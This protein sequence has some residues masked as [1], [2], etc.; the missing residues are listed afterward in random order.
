[1]SDRTF[2]FHEGWRKAIKALPDDVRLELYD[3]IVEY[4]FGESHEGL[5]SMAGIAFNFI[6]PTLD[7]DIRKKEAIA[8]RNRINGSKS[9]GRPKNVSFDQT[10]QNQEK[11]NETQDNPK[12]PVGYLGSEKKPSPQTP[13]KEKALTGGSDIISN[14]ISQFLGVREGDSETVSK[15]PRKKRIMVP[16]A[17]A[18]DVFIERYKSLYGEAPYVAQVE[19]THIRQLLLKIRNSRME[20]AKPLPVDD[21]SL[22][23]A[24]SD[25]LDSINKDWIYDNYSPQMINSKFNEIKS[26]I[27]NKRR[28][29]KD[30]T[31]EKDRRGT[32]VDEFIQGV[33]HSEGF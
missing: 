2:L 20:R 30:S 13:Y 17:R 31:R 15:S 12:N 3:A 25:F 26:Q 16:T 24:F 10:E 18:R 33:D 9:K 11:P 14:E 6:K 8:E 19:M 21:D 7:N 23:D 32:S 27:K 22:V 1:M 28:N 29:E 4:A 5:K